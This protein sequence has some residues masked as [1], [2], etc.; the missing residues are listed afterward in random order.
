MLFAALVIAGAYSFPGGALDD[1]VD[2]LSARFSKSV[3]AGIYE[4]D[5]VPAFTCDGDLGSVGRRLAKIAP[6]HLSECR[7]CLAI[8]PTRLPASI[9]NI[10]NLKGYAVSRTSAQRASLTVD[11]GFVNGNTGKGNILRTLSLIG[12]SWGAPLRVYWIYQDY[13]LIVHAVNCRKYDFLQ[14]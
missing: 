12:Y 13:G 9:A 4:P 5:R 11:K 3:V 2:S 6:F 1:L 10:R 14:A 7:T 8:E